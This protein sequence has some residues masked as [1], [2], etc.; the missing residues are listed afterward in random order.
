VFVSCV[1]I[2]DVKQRV[3]IKFYLKSGKTANE[4]YQDLKNVYGNDCLI[5]HS[6]D[7]D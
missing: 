4:L 3:T 1:K 5:A 2:F 7:D 6:S